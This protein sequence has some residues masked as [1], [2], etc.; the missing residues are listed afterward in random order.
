MSDVNL[1]ESL[2]PRVRQYLIERWDITRLDLDS[3]SDRLAVLR[4]M[5]DQFESNLA[6]RAFMARLVRNDTP[7]AARRGRE[8]I[9]GVFLDEVRKH[10]CVLR[11]GNGS[12]LAQS[13]WTMEEP[14]TLSGGIAMAWEFIFDIFWKGL[15]ATGWRGVPYGIKLL[16][17]SKM[18]VP[19]NGRGKEVPHLMIQNIG[20]SE[21]AR[22][23]GHATIHLLVGMAASEALGMPLKVQLQND[24]HMRPLVEIAGF[25]DMGPIMT[26]EENYPYYRWAVRWPTGSVISERDFRNISMAIG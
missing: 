20:T 14:L 13:W 4:F 6:T 23:H 18:A 11:T 3:N 21:E 9:Q 2:D 24:R 22:R 16:L 17:A 19:K 1:L 15:E 26:P 8:L 10:G 7:E 25:Q 12:E 5:D